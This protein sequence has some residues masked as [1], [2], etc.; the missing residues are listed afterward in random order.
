MKIYPI[1]PAVYPATRSYSLYRN[2][3]AASGSYTAGQCIGGVTTIN[4]LF[5]RQGGHARVSR[6]ALNNQNITPNAVVALLIS[7]ASFSTTFVDKT[8]VVAIQNVDLLQLQVEDSLTFSQIL[9]T[10]SVAAIANYTGIILSDISDSNTLYATLIAE[11][12]LTVPIN[13]SIYLSISLELE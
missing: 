13:S 4:G 12:S 8:S 10:E 5:A 7:G 3:I 2:A 9:T 6:I 11:S 1:P